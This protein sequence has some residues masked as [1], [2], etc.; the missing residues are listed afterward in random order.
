LWIQVDDKGGKD[1]ERAVDAKTWAI[2]SQFDLI[3]RFGCARFRRIFREEGFLMYNRRIFG[4]HGF[5]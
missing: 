1:I 3:R 5:K 2:S 4:E